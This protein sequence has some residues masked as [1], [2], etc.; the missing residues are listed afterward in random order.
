MGTRPLAPRRS[1]VG[2]ELVQLDLLALPAAMATY[3]VTL[4]N[5]NEGLNSTI[6]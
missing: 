3:K 2:N 4:V 1:R 6:D 5:A